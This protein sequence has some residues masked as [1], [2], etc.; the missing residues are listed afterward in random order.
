MV[1]IAP[2]VSGA[3]GASVAAEAPGPAETALTNV[4]VVRMVAAGDP[5]RDV[6]EA[7]RTHEEAFDLSPDMIEELKLAGVS[8]AILS[9]MRDRHAES[10]PPEVPAQRR[11]RGQ[12]PLVVTL[13]GGATL[14]VPAWA[15]E[16]AKE[17][18]RLPK[19][20]EQREVKDLAVFLSCI[21]AEHVP[22]LWRSKSPLGRDMVFVSR[23]RMLAFVAGDTPAGKDPRLKL[24]ARLEADVDEDEPHDLVLGVAARIGDHW[25][26][27]GATILKK[28]AITAGQKP[29]AGRID[30]VGRGF[31]F[32]IALSAPR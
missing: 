4:D 18:L 22:D 27:L 7:I 11:A 30:H 20:T 32:K 15:D 21:T 14:K 26:Q 16:D 6:I 17:K 3:C 25:I 31:D 29:L 28:V 10:A 8:A 12:V 2:V 13:N 9:A 1:A 5:E 19:E 24:P 23:H